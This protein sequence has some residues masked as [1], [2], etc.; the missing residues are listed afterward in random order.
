MKKRKSKHKTALKGN[1]GLGFTIKIQ[2]IFLL[3][4]TVVF[5][6]IGFFTLMLNIEKQELFYVSII[7]FAVCSFTCGYIIAYI[8]KNNYLI[9]GLFFTLP[10]NLLIT[11]ISA[12]TNSFKIDLTIL[13]SFIILIISGM[14]GGIAVSFRKQKPKVKLKRG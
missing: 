2:L 14:L 6:L 8:K 9:R 12:L 5:I 3:I 11:F 10:M 1:D 7:S 13:F 4:Y